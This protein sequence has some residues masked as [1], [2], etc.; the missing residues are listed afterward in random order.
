MEREKER[1]GHQAQYAEA[2]DAKQ[3]KAE[4]RAA[5]KDGFYKLFTETDPQKRGKALGGALNKLF[6]SCGILVE[7][8][9]FCPQRS[10]VSREKLISQ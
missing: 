3:K 9:G 8:R 2:L 6:K 5:L 7:Q 4:E 10:I 1:K